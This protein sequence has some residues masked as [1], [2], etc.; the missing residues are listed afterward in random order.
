M[1]QLTLLSI[2]FLFFINLITGQVTDKTK[3]TNLKSAALAYCWGYP[4]ASIFNKEIDLKNFGFDQQEYYDYLEKKLVEKL[5]AV[6]IKLLPLNQTQPVFSSMAKTM[7]ALN[8]IQG[9][10]APTQQQLDQLANQMEQLKKM[11]QMMNQ[12]FGGKGNGL[13]TGNGNN[14]SSIN[15]AVPIAPSMDAKGQEKPGVRAPNIYSDQ[16]LKVY[17]RVA[18]DMGADA[19]I[20]VHMKVIY[21]GAEVK[22]GLSS[23]FSLN[24]TYSKPHAFIILDVRVYDAD[25]NAIAVFSSNGHKEIKEM[26]KDEL[27]SFT[28][29]TG[30]FEEIRTWD[31]V[32]AQKLE[33]DAINQAVDALIKE[34]Q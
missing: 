31:Q 25:G 29:L 13:V 1:K 6:N 22:K 20:A 2:S 32:E 19:F 7:A 14:I 21:A 18:K 15:T 28:K 16:A 24:K 34:L 9:K 12:K 5:T 33:F 8:E 17:S 10:P 11:Q 3:L 26:S 4:E 23:M 30:Q 27:T